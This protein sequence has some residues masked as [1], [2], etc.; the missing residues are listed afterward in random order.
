MFPFLTHFTF[1]FSFSFLIYH[2]IDLTRN[3]ADRTGTSSHNDNSCVPSLFHSFTILD[4][5]LLLSFVCL[6]SPLQ[7][8]PSP[9]SFPS[10][11]HHLSLAV[12]FLM[13]TLP[14]CSVSYLFSPFFHLSFL[15]QFHFFIFLFSPPPLPRPQ[16]KGNRDAYLLCSTCSS[17]DV[18]S[19]APSP[20]KN[21]TLINCRN[22][23]FSIST[24][25]NP[26]NID[27]V[28]TV[29]CFV[30]MCVPCRT[31]SFVTR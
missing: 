19:P 4:P 7:T 12:V 2:S 5:P 10:H 26:S 31:Y 17:T 11:H 30:C 9:Y 6:F 22:E 15:V 21:V 18:H 23:L 20:P 29:M 28:I 24:T 8:C 3:L 16:N 14:M 1:T 27:Q 13:L 25:T